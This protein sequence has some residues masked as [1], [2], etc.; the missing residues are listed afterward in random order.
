MW[1]R[2]QALKVARALLD[3]AP[4][5]APLSIIRAILSIATFSLTAVTAG[6]APLQAQPQQQRGGEAGPG[7]PMAM[8]RRPAPG[9]LVEGGG[10][11]G[12]AFAEDAIAQAAAAAA[13]AEHDPLRRVALDTLRSAC[14]TP[15]LLPRLAAAGVISTLNAYVVELAVSP[16]VCPPQLFRLKN[17]QLLLTLPAPIFFRTLNSRYPC[18]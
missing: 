10:A 5:V 11:A 3:H 6:G 16:Q 15:A 14:L 7:A 9:M 2:V 8:G 17:R 12:G 1:E 18:S 13:A 4:D